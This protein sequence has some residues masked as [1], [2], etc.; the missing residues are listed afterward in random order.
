MLGGGALS[1]FDFR[2]RAAQGIIAVEEKGG[3]RTH[4]SEYPSTAV[5]SIAAPPCI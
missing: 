1:T 3:E 2:E 5:T 4:N